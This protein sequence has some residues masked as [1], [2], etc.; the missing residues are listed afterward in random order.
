MFNKILPTDSRLA[1]VSIYLSSVY[2]LSSIYPHTIIYMLHIFIMYVIY[3]YY[4]CFIFLLY[5][6]ICYFFSEFSTFQC[7]NFLFGL[8][9]ICMRDT[10]SFYTILENDQR[11]T[12][13]NLEIQLRHSP[14]I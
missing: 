14:G 3:F 5:I 7:S 8:S 10:L 11:A 1:L 13:K 4:L 2:H 6:C 12:G 9:S